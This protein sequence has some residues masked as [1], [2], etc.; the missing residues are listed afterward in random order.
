[1]RYFP[2]QSGPGIDSNKGA[3]HFP[4]AFYHQIALCQI[5]DTRWGSVVYPHTYT[6]I[7]G[8][9]Q[10]GIND[11]NE[12][13]NTLLYKNIISHILFLKG[14]CWLWV[15]DELETGTDCYID[16]KFFFDHS[17]TSFSSWLGCST[18]GHWGLCREAVGV[19]FSFNQLGNIC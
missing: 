5:Q 3:L 10:P 9:N 8:N 7:C 14:W 17:S 15:R 12:R 6:K 18:V 13:T 11:F 19:L 4:K 16:P 1:M 2:D